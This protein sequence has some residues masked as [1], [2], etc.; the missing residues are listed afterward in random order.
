MVRCPIVPMPVCGFAVSMTRA[1]CRTL[2]NISPRRLC[3]KDP[4]KFT[5]L[6]IRAVDSTESPLEEYDLR[7]QAMTPKEIVEIARA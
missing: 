3:P 6:V 7:G 5:E 4:L 1:C 2:S